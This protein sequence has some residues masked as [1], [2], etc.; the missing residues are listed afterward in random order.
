[1]QATVANFHKY[2]SHIKGSRNYKHIG[3]FQ[4]SGNKHQWNFQKFLKQQSSSSYMN[5]GSSDLH[6]KTGSNGGNNF[7]KFNTECS[8]IR[9]V[10]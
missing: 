6:R 5:G 3:G 7:K 8:F 10:T 9:Y 2:K 4:S 1:M